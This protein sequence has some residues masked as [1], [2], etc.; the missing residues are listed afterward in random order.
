MP[1]YGNCNDG[2]MPFTKRLCAG[3]KKKIKTSVKRNNHS[4]KEIKEIRADINPVELEIDDKTESK[5]D[6]SFPDFHLSIRRH[7]YFTLL[8]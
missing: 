7:G 1:C 5:K 2:I 4:K 3:L 6:A 8:F